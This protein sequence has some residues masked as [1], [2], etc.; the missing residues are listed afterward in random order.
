VE[1]GGRVFD[2]TGRRTYW[3]YAGQKNYVYLQTFIPDAGYDLRVIVIGSLVFGFYRDVPKGEFRA[4]GMNLIRWDPPPPAAMRIARRVAQVLD[5][6]YVA[7]DLLAGAADDDLRIIEISSFT[8]V[9]MVDAMHKDGVLGAYVFDDEGD[10]CRFV[11]MRVW[12]PE[13][14]LKRVLETR[15]LARE[16][17]AGGTTL[18]A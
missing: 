6:P 9:D 8:Q 12:T 4:S 13:L 10:E 7:V 2:F 14:T 3:P 5:L 15:W 16:H 11:P 17:G 18:P 1:V